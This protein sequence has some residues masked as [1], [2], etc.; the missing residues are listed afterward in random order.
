MRKLYIFTGLIVFVVGSCIALG[1]WQLSRAEEKR[2]LLVRQA[3]QSE[4][5]VETWREAVDGQILNLEGMYW[6]K[7][8]FLLD[9]QSYEGV[10]GYSVIAPFLLNERPLLENAQTEKTNKPLIKQVVMVNLGWV[11]ANINRAILPNVELPNGTVNIRV[12][13]YKPSKSVFRLTENQYANAG[14]PK[15]IQYFSHDFFIKEVSNITKDNIQLIS[16]ETRIEEQQA[17]VQVRHWHYRQMQPE[18]HQAYA[19]QWFGLA[20]VVSVLGGLFWRNVWLK[21]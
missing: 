9:N 10:A 21:R 4:V 3:S 1:F 17:G 8:Y 18:K 2:L 13:V 14:W 16:Y 12:R 20:L 6:D 11:K 19:F 5:S 7:H 15:R